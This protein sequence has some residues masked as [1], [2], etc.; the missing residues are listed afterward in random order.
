MSEYGRSDNEQQACEAHKGSHRG[1]LCIGVCGGRVADGQFA[2]GAEWVQEMAW[3]RLAVQ[4]AYFKTRLV[5]EKQGEEDA[6]AG[7]IDRTEKR[8]NE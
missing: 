8:R 4:Q 1:M 5:K 3:S 2:E 6:I 7:D